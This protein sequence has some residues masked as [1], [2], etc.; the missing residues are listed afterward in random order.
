MIESYKQEIAESEQK[1]EE[2][3]ESFVSATQG[4]FT[5]ARVREEF[6]RFSTL[7]SMVEHNETL[8]ESLEDKAQKELGDTNMTFQL[9]QRGN[10]VNASTT[11][12]L[13]RYTQEEQD[14]INRCTSALLLVIGHHPSLLDSTWEADEVLQNAVNDLVAGINR[15]EAL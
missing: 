5:P 10:A 15:T 14:R 11:L 1:M 6:R 13:N 8:I 3:I 7:V 12:I 4:V 9:T 2:I